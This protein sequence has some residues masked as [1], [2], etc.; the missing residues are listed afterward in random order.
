MTAGGSGQSI[1]IGA[2][3][4]VGGDQTAIAEKEEKIREL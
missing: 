2:G 1:L 4:V 3:Q